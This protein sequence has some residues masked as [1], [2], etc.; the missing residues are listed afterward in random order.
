MYLCIKFITVLFLIW[1]YVYT[2]SGD[3]LE[4]MSPQ[5]IELCANSWITYILNK[6]AKL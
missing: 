2:N 4:P 5:L 3:K 1:Y 6:K